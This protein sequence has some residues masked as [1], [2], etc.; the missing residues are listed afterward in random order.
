[1]LLLIVLASLSQF[2]FKVGA[3]QTSTAHIWQ[4]LYH[5]FTLLGVLGF[6]L[7]FPL[8]ISVHRLWPFKKMPVRNLSLVLSLVLAVLFLGEIITLTRAVGISMIILGAILL[9]RS[10]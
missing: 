7:T 1:M 10:Q 5:P 6:I 4:T 9:G 8:S 2:F 3:N